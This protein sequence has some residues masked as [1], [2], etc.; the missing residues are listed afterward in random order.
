[1]ILY[2]FIQMSLAIE[3]KVLSPDTSLEL[4]VR[5]T[6]SIYVEKAQILQVSDLQNKVKL[7][8]KKIG[9]TQLRIGQTVYD[10]WV[11][12]SK[13]FAT[14][15]KLLAWIKD[16]R[17]PELQI[18]DYVIFIAGR[19]LRTEDWLELG[20]LLTTHDDYK[21]SAQ[22]SEDVRKSILERIKDIL[23]QNNLSFTHFSPQPDWSLFLNKSSNNALAEELKSY[24]SIL[25]P[26][27]IQI[28]S[29]SQIIQSA[30]LI[31]VSVLAVEVQRSEIRNLGV[32]WPASTSVLA[33]LPFSKLTQASLLVEIQ[34]LEE[35]NKARTLAKPTLI[36]QSGEE[37]TFHSGGEFPIKAM[38]RLQSSVVW[39]KYGLLLKIT[40]RADSSGRMDV[41]IDCEFSMLDS[42]QDPSGVPGLLVH[43]VTSHI[44]L[45]ESKTLAL[46]GLI[47]DE[48][49]QGRAGLPGLLEIPL[50]HSLFSSDSF[51]KNQSELIFF[52]TPRVVK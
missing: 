44:N 34:H 2:L 31:E 11:V 14:Y 13:T 10:V 6:Q 40:P 5:S 45:E 48:W 15:Q 33:E 37:A 19:I 41:K 30:P 20:T 36:S 3:L 39:K 1:M 49:R 29:S 17:G 9:R 7:R 51:Q 8:G 52:I 12:N 22:L 46:S 25:K 35:K 21:I 23:Q 50:L 18:H 43:R 28:K 32:Q 27:G 47:K 4:P 16:K 26:Y 42:R 24:Q 38:T